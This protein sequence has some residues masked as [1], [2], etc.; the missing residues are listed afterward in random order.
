MFGK[1]LDVVPPRSIRD[2]ERVEFRERCQ[3]LRQ[4]VGGRHRGAVDED[5]D[6]ADP[7]GKGGLNLSP[8]VIIGLSHATG[9]GRVRDARPLA[10]DDDQLNRG[11]SQRVQNRAFEVRAPLNR[12]NVPKELLPSENIDEVVRQSTRRHQAVGAAIAD[13]NPSHG[14]SLGNRKRLT[15]RTRSSAHANRACSSTDDRRERAHR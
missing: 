7:F 10:A 6:H 5:R 4:F 13:K 14:S 9:S 1:L 8:H 2:F 3:C 15:P 11:G 12:V